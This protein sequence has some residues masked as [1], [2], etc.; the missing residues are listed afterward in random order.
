[1]EGGV[2]EIRFANLD[3]TL[4]QCRLNFKDIDT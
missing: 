1:M 3:M 4:R 2:V